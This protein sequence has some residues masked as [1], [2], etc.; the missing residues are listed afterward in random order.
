MPTTLVGHPES[1]LTRQAPATRVWVAFCNSWELPP[2]H[3]SVAIFHQLR[4]HRQL[5]L[6]HTGT[7]QF[8]TSLPWVFVCLLRWVVFFLAVGFYKFHGGAFPIEF[9]SCI[10]AHLNRATSASNFTFLISLQTFSQLFLSSLSKGYAAVSYQSRALLL[11]AQAA[12]PRG[13]LQRAATAV[14]WE[15]QK[16][17]TGQA[18][19]TVWQEMGLDWWLLA[20]WSFQKKVHEPQWF[21]FPTK[22]KLSWPLRLC[23]AICNAAH[24]ICLLSQDAREYQEGGRFISPNGFVKRLVMPFRSAVVP[25]TLSWETLS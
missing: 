6:L 8:L 1:W 2:P 12:Q 25:Q 16:E 4:W 9:L 24:C 23:L 7:L 10:W 18:G 21:P 22:Y 11:G 13:V 20:Q 14:T 3:C 19:V 5:W 17:M 15:G